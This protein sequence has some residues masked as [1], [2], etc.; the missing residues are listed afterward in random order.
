ML[1]KGEIGATIFYAGFTVSNSDKENQAS[2]EEKGSKVNLNL[3][4]MVRK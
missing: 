2:S 3:I 1:E 4:F